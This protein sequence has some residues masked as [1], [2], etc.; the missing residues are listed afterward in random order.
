MAK[1]DVPPLEALW[2]LY[3]VGGL[4]ESR[5]DATVE[6]CRSARAC[7]DCAAGGR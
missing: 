3:A 1:S 4:D 7:L 5:G 2:A 6:A